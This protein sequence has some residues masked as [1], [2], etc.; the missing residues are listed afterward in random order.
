MLLLPLGL[1]PAWIARNELGPGSL[2][3]GPLEH[4][5]NLGACS[6]SYSPQAAHYFGSGA[7]YDHH[8]AR[9]REWENARWPV[10]FAEE[11]TEDL[12]ASSFFWLAGWQE[13]V[14]VQ[15]DQHARFRYQDSLQRA[16]GTA[17]L[18]VVD[19]YRTWLLDALK[20]HDIKVLPRCWGDATWACC[21]TIDI[22]YIKKW[23][24]GM[25][26]REVVEYLLL[27][28]QGKPAPER[29][30]RFFRF[31]A[32][33]LSPGDIYQKAMHRIHATVLE[34]GTAT[35]FFKAA[36]HGSQDVHY[37]LRHPFLRSYLARI[38]KS[39]CAIGLH[40]SYHAYTHQEYLVRERDTL[41]EQV[42]N[43]PQSIRQHFLRYEAP[44]TPRLQ[45][46][47]NFL[48]DSTLGFAEHEGF[49]SGTCM[50]FQRF[51]SATNTV[52][53]CWEMPLAVMESALFNRRKLDLSEAVAATRDV[54]AQC[55]RFGGVAVL[56]WH[57]VL[58]DELDHP[59]WG[60]HFLESMAEAKAQSAQIA[61]LENA[62]AG[63]LRTDSE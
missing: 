16:F 32:D 5:H 10:L 9:M 4:K 23:R 52:G 34:H 54:L 21:P 28:R 12:V 48:I 13:H 25:I 27:D 3:Y 60:D 62:L 43:R 31:L 37:S 41:A 22:D 1:E 53:D 55:R 7:A 38:Q 14:T 44:V 50:P 29:L 35:F 61:S 30:S 42:G 19:A 8:Q 18:P 58:W 15:R 11:D 2:Y 6:V 24:K 17:A 57:P 26:F 56:L 45:D 49:R 39:G 46:S 20:E 36:A 33:W 63:W 59:G 51:D 47:A 40:P